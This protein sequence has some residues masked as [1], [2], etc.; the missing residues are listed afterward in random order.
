M[1]LKKYSR[2]N[3]SNR[4]PFDADSAEEHWS[5][6][7]LRTVIFVAAQGTVPRSTLA[8]VQRQLP[9]SDWFE[10]QYRGRWLPMNDYL[11]W[12][13]VQIAP[14][15]N[16][17]LR[18]LIN[19]ILGMK[20]GVDDEAGIHAD[21]VRTWMSSPDSERLLGE[22]ITMPH[23]A[24]GVRLG[25]R[26]GSATIELYRQALA[27]CSEPEENSVLVSLIRIEDAAA[28]L[29]R[30]IYEITPRHI[31]HSTMG[32]AAVVARALLSHEREVIERGDEIEVLKKEGE[33]LETVVISTTLK[34]EQFLAALKL[35]PDAIRWKGLKKRTEKKGSLMCDVRSN[36]REVTVQR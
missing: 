16:I 20:G 23:T 28:I 27:L 33:E 14:S 36:L 1:S 5:K 22:V 35:P 32:N 12:E 9:S 26:P 7:E 10:D 30:T 6:N 15:R 2:K 17:T 34:K 21:D 18:E 19:G 13:E 3:S 31:Y 29:R 24:L 4:E 25:R 8:S 11:S